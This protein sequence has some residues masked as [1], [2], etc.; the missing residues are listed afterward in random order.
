MSRS[1]RDR[2]RAERLV[3]HRNRRPRNVHS[4]PSFF[5]TAGQRVCLA[6]LI[7]D[8]NQLE[9]KGYKGQ[10][11]GMRWERGAWGVSKAL[12]LTSRPICM[13]LTARI[14]GIKCVSQAARSVPGYAGVWTSSSQAV[15][16]SGT[17]KC[18]GDAFS[19]EAVTLRQMRTKRCKRNIRHLSTASAHDFQRS[20][21]SQTLS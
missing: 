21:L 17:I 11:K 6:I 15:L 1:V 2:T 7:Y 20:K 8:K 9:Q 5:L 18:G 13:T 10:Q 3:F 12:L 4:T 19:W 16:Y 14:Q